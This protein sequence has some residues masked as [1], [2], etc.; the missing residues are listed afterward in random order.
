M[1]FP[2]FPRALHLRSAKFA[3]FAIISL[4]FL[5]NFTGLFFSTVLAPSVSAANQVETIPDDIP[6]SGDC[7]LDWIIY[8]TGKSAGVDPRFIH[9]VIKQESKYDPKAVSHVG[10]E[11]LMQMMPATAKRFGLKDPFD[12]KANVEAG[13]KYLKW[14][15]KRFDGD[16]TLAL[17]GYN[18]GEGSVD[19]YKGVPPYNETQN[20]VKK[21]VKTYGKTYHPILPPEDAQL[22]FHLTNDVSV[23][24]GL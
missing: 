19:K 18:A 5:T 23:N 22:A 3:P 4:F 15:L 6:L 17:A 20:Y 11:G 14:L 10:A 7:D 16:V 24:V 21:I 1:T 8:R 9:A 12:P 2:R 13:T